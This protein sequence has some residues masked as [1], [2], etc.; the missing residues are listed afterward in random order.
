MQGE[1]MITTNVYTITEVTKSI[2]PGKW[3]VNYLK[4]GIE[5]SVAMRPSLRGAAPG[6]HIEIQIDT[7]KDL[8][9]SARLVR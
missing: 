9:V 6:K 7:V 8:V 4:D 5:W 1:K 3:H 2:L